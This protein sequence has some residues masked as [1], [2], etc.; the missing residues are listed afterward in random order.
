MYSFGRTCENP[1]SHGLAGIED[2]S[3]VCEQKRQQLQ[4]DVAGSSRT[5]GVFVHHE[6]A[7]QGMLC[8]DRVPQGH[9]HAASDESGSALVPHAPG[10]GTA[11]AHARDRVAPRTGAARP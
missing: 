2:V 9:G 6:G 1:T 3:E 10:N 7:K 4:Q 8:H 5:P 11:R